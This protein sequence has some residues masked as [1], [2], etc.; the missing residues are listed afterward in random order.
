MFDKNNSGFLLK[1]F[2]ITGIGLALQACNGEKSD[3]VTDVAVV[4]NATEIQWHKG[5]VDQAFTLAKQQNKPLYFYWGAEW[6]PPCQE[7]KHTVFT[8]PKFITQS[9]LFIPVYLDGDTEQAQEVGERFAVFGYPTM[10]VFDANGKEITRIPGGI[11]TRRY[12]D[13]LTLSLN[14]GQRMDQ[15]IA[16]ARATPASLSADELT[17][18]AFYSWGQDNLQLGANEAL[19]LLKSLAFID[20]ANDQLAASRLLLAYLAKSVDEDVDDLTPEEKNEVN[21]KLLNSLRRPDTVLAN[22]D[23]LSFYPRE[24]VQL[25]DLPEPQADNLMQ[26]WSEAVDRQRNSPLLSKAERLGTWLAPIH[27]YWLQYPNAEQ[28]PTALADDVTAMVADFNENTQG[29]ERQ[30]VINRAGNVLR[31][32][33]LYDQAKT[34]IS[35]ELKIS[36]SP[37][38]FMSSLAEIAQETDK[39]TEV[40]EWRQKAYNAAEGRATRFQWGVEYVDAL[41]QHDPNNAQE[42]TKMS[43]A[44]LQHV[45]ASEVFSGRNL[46][47]LQTLLDSM[48]QWQGEGRQETLTHFVGQLHNLCEQTS[49]ES[50]QR[51]QCAQLLA[52]L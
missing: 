3:S 34:L 31:A 24:I 21:T 45:A 12:L 29:D 38:Y 16:K 4:D 28:I 23:F 43:Q 44:I 5:N 27:F 39:P 8:H 22:I 9:E 17:Q 37:Y 11:D 36:K 52:A 46:G 40:L 51:Q 30:S 42:I 13:V 19:T 20:G 18:L 26:T 14:Q 41:I 1:I 47:R 50:P 2:F 25:L 7:I 49:G 33:N 6:C 48:D 32:A 15:L 10:I 35:A